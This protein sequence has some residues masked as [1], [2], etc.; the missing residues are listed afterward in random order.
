MRLR[1]PKLLA[2]KYTKPDKIGSIYVNPAWKTDNSRSLWE[3]YETSEAA[4]KV[5]RVDLEPSWILV[6]APNSGVFYTY[7][8]SWREIFILAASSIRRIIPWTTG[9]HMKIKGRR[10]LV[11]QDEAKK[12][13]GS[14]VLPDVAQR[15]PVTGRIVER[16]DEVEDAL[17]VEGA[18]V[19]YSVY[20]GVEVEVGG[21][22]MMI[23][24][25]N[26]ILGWPEEGE[27][28]G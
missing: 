17:S 16:G 3:V 4:N 15:R 1:G 9:E 26:Q 7:D 24:E 21:V 8:E 6:T 11:R 25:E 22:Q 13:H 2:T 27:E 28:I 18:R 19:L 10:V 14:I 12:A 23:L 5:L 20:A